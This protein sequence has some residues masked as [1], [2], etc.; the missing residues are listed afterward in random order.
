MIAA[1]HTPG[2]FP[3]CLHGGQKK[4]D[5]GADDRDDD[6]KLDER[7]ANEPGIVSP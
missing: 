6:E 4:G 2:G 3:R 7:K 5:Q 1:L